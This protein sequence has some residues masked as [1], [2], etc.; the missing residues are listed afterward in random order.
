MEMCGWIVVWAKNS[1]LEISINIHEWGE[2]SE[3]TCSSKYSAS[4]RIPRT[5]TGYL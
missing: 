5:G 1:T 2:E 4:A 3:A